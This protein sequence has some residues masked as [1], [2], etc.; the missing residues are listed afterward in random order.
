MADGDDE[1]VTRIHRPNI[2]ERGRTFIAVHEAA[3]H[4]AVQ[5][6]AEDAG[7]HVVLRAMHLPAAGAGA[8]WGAVAVRLSPAKPI[9]ARP[10]ANTAWSQMS[11][12]PIGARPNSVGERNA[13]TTSA[14]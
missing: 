13:M 9:H 6:I 8:Q 14:A 2:H 1:Q 12:P 4:P 11:F 5:N 10:A 3:R 7:L